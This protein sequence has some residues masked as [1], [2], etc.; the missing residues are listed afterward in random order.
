MP[1]DL[2][3][4]AYATLRQEITQ[5]LLSAREKSRQIVER[6]M[7]S[8]YWLVGQLLDAHL[9]AHGTRAHYGEQVVQQLATDLEIDY[10][11]LY[12]MLRVYRAL[13]IF[14]STGKLTWT[15]YLTLLKAPEETRADYAKRAAEE[16]LSVRQ[17]QETIATD[18]IALSPAPTTDPQTPPSELR[19]RRGVLY[20]YRLIELLRGHDERELVLD[21]GFSLRRQVELKTVED[22][23]VG[24]VV[25]AKRQ[26]KGY[27]LINAALTRDRLFTFAAHVKKV[28][29][30]DTL[31]VEV[32][33]GFGCWMQQRLRLRGID[34]PE[35]NTPEGRRAHAFV[36]AALSQVNFVVIKTTRPDKYDRYLADVFYLSNA[37]D[38]Q[39]VVAEGTYLN[40]LLLKEGLANAFV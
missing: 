35:L 28:V 14:R 1:T 38:A 39:Q 31:L 10:R 25:A 30:G 18:T 36:Q 32:D 24:T 33:C 26:G 3:P 34:T 13:P 22:P 12:E 23:Q 27:T 11:R 29:D 7:T 40:S 19:A 4:S 20:A 15:H 5:V 8:A 6:E 37:Q 16:G 9:N 21:L 2:T 17:L